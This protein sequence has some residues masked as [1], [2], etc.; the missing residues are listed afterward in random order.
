MR[1]TANVK[2]GPTPHIDIN[3]TLSTA[4][5]ELMLI[6]KLPDD[7]DFWKENKM[8]F[9]WAERSMFYFKIPECA[10]WMNHHFQ[11]LGF[12]VWILIAGEAP[13]PYYKIQKYF[14]K[15]RRFFIY[16]D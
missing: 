10:I 16:P 3:K 14:W 2:G 1:S 15:S 5:N 6:L 4:Q 7:S 12:G 8:N 13:R 11:L 9:M